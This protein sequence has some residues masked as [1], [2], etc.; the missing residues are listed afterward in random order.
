MSRIFDDHSAMNRFQVLGGFKQAT[1][2]D[3]VKSRQLQKVFEKEIDR[4]AQIC[5][6]KGLFMMA[7]DLLETRHKS[8]YKTDP[9]IITWTELLRENDSDVFGLC[10]LLNGTFFR[11]KKIINY[12]DPSA[13]QIYLNTNLSDRNKDTYYKVK[14]KFKDLVDFYK[15]NRPK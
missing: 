12:F 14:E 3:S 7:N 2:I 6:S 9:T 4:E 5:I 15:V 13:N 1:Y 11:R 8:M 10:A